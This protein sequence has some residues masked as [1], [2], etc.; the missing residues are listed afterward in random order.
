LVE[1][2]GSQQPSSIGAGSENGGK[3]GDVTI[4][5][6]QLIVRDRSR[7]NVSSIRVDVRQLTPIQLAQLQQAGL[8]DLL[9]RDPGDPGSINITARSL[10]LD[11]QS[12][13]NASSETGNGGNITVRSQDIQLRRQS[14]FSAAGSLTGVTKEGSID[15]NTQS[16]VLLEGSSIITSANAP[17]GGSNINIQPR[18]DLGL[19]LFQSADSIINARGQLNIEGDIQPPHPNIPQIEVVDAT[20]LIADRCA[21]ARQGSSFVVTGRGGIPASPDQPLGGENLLVDLVTVDT[22]EHGS[23]VAQ[24]S[25]LWE[26]GSKM[27]NT[28]N[29]IVEATGWIINEQGQVVLVAAHTAAAYNPE[30]IPI[31]C[32]VR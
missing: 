22:G 19:A 20:N 13:L 3:A 15:I 4:Q 12:D 32:H 21:P 7:I 2:S 25:R 9:N 16:L 30:I 26:Q 5:T 1:L 6:G 24:A 29:E 14:L 8:G 27:P 28:N 10:R 23:S 18:N 17:Q 11:N 31:N